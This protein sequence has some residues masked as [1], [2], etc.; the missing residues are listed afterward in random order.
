MHESIIQTSKATEEI[1]NSFVAQNKH[2]AET[3][4]AEKDRMLKDASTACAAG[5]RY[6]GHWLNSTSAGEIGI[7]FDRQIATG[8]GFSLEGVLFDPTNEDHTKPF[9]GVLEG[10]G[11]SNRPFLLTLQTTKDQ[12]YFH[13]VLPNNGFC[14]LDDPFAKPFLDK[15]SGFFVDI[16]SYKLNVIYKEEKR[17]FSGSINAYKFNPFV[18]MC[19][20]P[21]NLFFSQE[22]N[23]KNAP[24]ISPNTTENTN[25][26]NADIGDVPK[27]NKTMEN[28]KKR[29]PEI[30]HQENSV[31]LNEFAESF[32]AARGQKDLPKMKE[33]IQQ[34]LVKYPDTATTHYWL[35]NIA[36]L[37]R[38][39][40]ALKKQH[41]ILIS[42]FSETPDLSA[43]REAQYNECLKDLN[44][45][46]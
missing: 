33:I 20:Q 14:S 16:S 10:D 11:S 23:L 30:V 29:T 46:N 3:E 39:I 38:D 12:G 15:T 21:I 26:S 8:S 32:R 2:A 22:Y 42:D 45:T 40:D 43:Q 31:V 28:G 18:S 35:M 44:G 4:A 17:T 19:G 13:V 7:R 5:K 37:E 27:T 24:K 41:Q 6:Y 9:T 25:K 36:F 1:Y 34:V